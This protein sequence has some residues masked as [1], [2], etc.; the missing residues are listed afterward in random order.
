MKM[1]L[2]IIERELN[3]SRIDYMKY[4]QDRKHKMARV[5]P[6]KRI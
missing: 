5:K 2:G 3:A 6:A 1:H 4:I